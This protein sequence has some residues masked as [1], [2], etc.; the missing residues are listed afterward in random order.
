DELEQALTRLREQYQQLTQQ[1]QKQNPRYDQIQE[2]TNFSVQQIQQLIVED[3]ETMLLEYFLGRNASYVW[4]IT[5]NDARVYE[6]PKADAIT[7]A[8]QVV[9]ELLAKN[10][11]DDTQKQ[12]SKAGSDLAQM[13]LTPLAKQPAVK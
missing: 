6:L 13:I 11:D 10:P 1:L 2:P 5:R 7:S 4:A 3:D 12:F 8:V 9:Y